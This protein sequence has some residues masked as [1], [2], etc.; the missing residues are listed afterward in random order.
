MLTEAII[1]EVKIL[2]S[3]FDTIDQMI[4]FVEGPKEEA[5]NPPPSVF[6]M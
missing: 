3:H 6:L 1:M 2:H 4:K 5:I